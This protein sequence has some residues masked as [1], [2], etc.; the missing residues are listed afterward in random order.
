MS[1]AN[2]SRDVDIDAY[3]LQKDTAMNPY[4]VHMKTDVAA[5][6]FLP[7]RFRSDAMQRDVDGGIRRELIKKFDRKIAKLLKDMQKTSEECQKKVKKV[8]T[9]LQ[10]IAEED[11][12][13]QTDRTSLTDF[14]TKM[15]G[16]QN[17]V[18]HPQFDVLKPTPNVPLINNGSRLKPTPNVPLINNGSR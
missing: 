10:R 12:K 8:E 18:N 14:Q 17:M 1:H 11:K 3:V 5:A 7:Q 15:V 2:I 4:I 13:N 6:K 16:F 9:Q